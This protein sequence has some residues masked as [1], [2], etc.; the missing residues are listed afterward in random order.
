MI[1][2]KNKRYRIEAIPKSRVN[3][4]VVI[5]TVTLFFVKNTVPFPPDISPQGLLRRFSAR[6]IHLPTKLVK[7]IHVVIM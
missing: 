4:S 5:M 6:D 3:E 1:A 2:C 7:S